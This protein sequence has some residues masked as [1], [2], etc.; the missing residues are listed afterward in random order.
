MDFWVALRR[1]E[2][3]ELELENLYVW[4]SRAYESDPSVSA[5]FRNLGLEERAHANILRYQQKVF[6]KNRHLFKDIEI[7]IGIMDDIMRRSKELRSSE[8]APTTE[9]ALELSY[10][11]ENSIAEHYYV[12]AGRQSNPDLKDLL[13][14]LAAGCN[15]HHRRLAQFF[16]SVG[17][18]VKSDD[19]FDIG[20]PHH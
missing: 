10:E 19:D 4:F 14:T 15:E 2:D 11:I 17:L 1:L 5:L 20:R 3:F 6:L 8:A 13:T 12:L 16:G 7:D 9:E 18:Q